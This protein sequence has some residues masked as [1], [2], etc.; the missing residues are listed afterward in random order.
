MKRIYFTVI[1][2]VKAEKNEIWK[3]YIGLSKY[4]L[5]MGSFFLAFWLIGGWFYPATNLVAYVF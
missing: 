3:L 4:I 2:W 1:I 5:M